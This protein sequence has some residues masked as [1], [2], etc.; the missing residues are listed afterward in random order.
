M[1][2]TNCEKKAVTLVLR[3]FQTILSKGSRSDE[4]AGEK[5]HRTNKYC[6]KICIS[7]K[8]A[9]KKITK[10]QNNY[11]ISHSILVHQK[12]KRKQE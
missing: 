12:N 2:Y 4:K 11:D 10:K 6:K 9:N 3:F 5:V 7:L 1:G 8:K